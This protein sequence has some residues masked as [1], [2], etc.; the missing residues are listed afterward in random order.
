MSTTTHTDRSF[1]KYVTLNSTDRN[2][3]KIQFAHTVLVLIF[4]LYRRFC[5]VLTW[6]EEGKKI[7]KLDI[8]RRS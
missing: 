6:V 1:M 5:G 7:K 4:I 2:D 3:L 8:A